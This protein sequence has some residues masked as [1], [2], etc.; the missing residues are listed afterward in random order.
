MWCKLF[1]FL[2]QD[3]YG[4]EY[5]IY[6]Y[7]LNKSMPCCIHTKALLFSKVQFQYVTTFFE[8]IRTLELSS[9]LHTQIQNYS[10]TMRRRV[11]FYLQQNNATESVLLLYKEVPLMTVHSFRSRITILYHNDIP[12]QIKRYWFKFSCDKI[13]VTYNYFCHFSPKN[14]F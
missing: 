10:R 3:K 6:N 2:L 11:Y 9:Q 5:Y 14:K 8:F 13:F 7:N 1:I 4:K 12:Y